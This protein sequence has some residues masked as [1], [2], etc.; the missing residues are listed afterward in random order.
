MNN[1]T[2]W[3]PNPRVYSGTRAIVPYPVSHDAIGMKG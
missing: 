3:F 2:V 1:P